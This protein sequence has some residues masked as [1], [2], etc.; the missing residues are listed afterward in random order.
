MVI[1]SLQETEQVCIYLNLPYL[2]LHIVWW[3]IIVV[4]KG[5]VNGPRSKKTAKKCSNTA[6]SRASSICTGTLCV[7]DI[8]Q[9][10][11]HIVEKSRDPCS[12][13]TR[14]H[15]SQW[16]ISI[17]IIGF[18]KWFWSAED[19]NKYLDIN[20]YRNPL[21]LYRITI[22]PHNWSKCSAE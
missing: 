6:K 8:G 1:H 16:Y 3:S 13:Y 22:F 10:C 12:G 5:C 4:K 2:G 7:S 18:G 11:T 17:I 21:H 14:H 9:C 19:A 15:P 20:S